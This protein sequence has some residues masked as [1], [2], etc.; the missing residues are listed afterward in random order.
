MAARRRRGGPLYVVEHMEEGLEDWCRL[1]YTHMCQIVPT[2]RLLFLRW[3]AGEDPARLSKDARVDEP[4]LTAPEGFQELRHRLPLSKSGGSSSSTKSTNTND[5]NTNSNSNNNSNN[6]DADQQ[7]KTEAQ[8]ET[9]AVPL[10]AG[11]SRLPPWDR[12][13][14]LDM[15]AEEALQ[16]W[17]VANFDALVFGGILGNVHELGDGKYGSDDRTAELRD[18]KFVHRRHLGEMQMTTDTA[19]LF[20]HKVLEEAMALAEIPFIDSPEIRAL[21]EGEGEAAPKEK[22]PKQK[23]EDDLFG[24]D[25]G[26]IVMEGFRYYAE[27]QPDGTRQPKMPEGMRELQ[28]SDLDKDG[29]FMD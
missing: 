20:C 8:T 26:F 11:A 27:L 24:D 10:S 16:P 4:P 5:D 13:C 14:L 9:E 25:D 22:K 12:I 18:F 7:T 28:L 29:L 6:G 1:E 3:P 19:V 23:D 15:D 2:D 21:G 17:D